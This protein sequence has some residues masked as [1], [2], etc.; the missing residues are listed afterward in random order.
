MDRRIPPFQLRLGRLLVEG[1]TINDMF[2][3][4]RKMGATSEEIDGLYELI[5]KY[6][7]PRGKEKQND[8]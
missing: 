8:E 5:A 6:A 2:T 4:M 7:Q 1:Y 3:D